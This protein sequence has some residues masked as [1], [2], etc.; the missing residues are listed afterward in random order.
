MSSR[1]QVSICFFSIIYPTSGK[2]LSIK[3]TVEI[4]YHLG[5][6]R[7]IRKAVENFEKMGLESII[8]RR[9][10]DC[11][12][13]G[14][15]YE[16]AEP[17]KQYAYDHKD[18]RALFLDKAY[19]ER[20]LGVLR[21]AY[22]ECKEYAAV[23]AGPAVMESFGEKPFAPKAKKE[24]YRLDE[25]QQRLAVELANAVGSLVSEYINEEERSFTIIAFPLPEIGEPFEDIFREI[26]HINTLDYKLYQSV[27]QALIDALNKGTHVLIKGKGNNCT[28]LCVQLYPL[29]N[30]DKESIFENCVADVNIPVGEVFTSPVLK[31]TDGVLYVSQVYLN[32][33]EYRD[34]KL[35]FRDGMVAD[36]SCSNFE[37]ASEGRRYI[38]ENILRNHDSLPMGEFAIGTNTTAYVA[39][40]KYHLADK[41][42]ILIAEKMGPHFAV[43]DT[44]YSR[45][46]DVRIYNPDGKE[47]VAKENEVSALRHED[48]NKA[49]FNCHTDITIPYDELGSIEA[50]CA[51]GSH[52]M[53]IED[54]RFV[55]PGTEILN[56][57][58]ESML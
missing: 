10:V 19:V 11:I 53:L 49:Y 18:D 20:R 39:A 8:C 35:V 50:V 24:A 56:E 48:V 46:E 2:D 36:Y 7:V 37:D 15:G 4:R 33:L 45:E 30:P 32:E 17:N 14:T 21:T 6:E 57:P 51:D 43:G 27:Q 1:T 40:Q 16:G 29:R 38:R 23:Y 28:D 54:G 12:S 41:L 3:K 31:Q 26:I 25:K 13:P 34:L 42:P 22:E 44:C 58:F 52:I 55:L 47:I 9:A 5:F